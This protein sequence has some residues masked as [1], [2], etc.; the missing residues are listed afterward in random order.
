MVSRNYYV[1]LGV[2]QLDSPRRIRE[3]FHDLAWRYHPDRAGN[4][5]SHLFQ[6]LVEAYRVLSHPDARQE[7]DRLLREP[8]ASLTR[9]EEPAPSELPVRV[10][11]TP[12]VEPVRPLQYHYVARPPMHSL[13][14]RYKASLSREGDRPL[15][16]LD[17]ELVLSPDEALRGG[18]VTLEIPVLHPCVTCQGAGTMWMARCQACEGNGATPE[19]RPFT[20]HLPPM[21]P[22]ETVEL[23]LRGLG[24]HG[25]YLRVRS[26]VANERC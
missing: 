3:A 10:P 1:I 26:R 12:S 7:Y 25:M 23:A 19:L 11:W 18:S 8:A 13:L 4:V 6:E 20:V 2:G 16:P 15:E 21:R 24:L 9:R 22:D 17:I 14:R 5:A